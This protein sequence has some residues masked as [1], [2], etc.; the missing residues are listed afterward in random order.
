MRV[1]LLLLLSTAGAYAQGDGFFRLAYAN[2]YFGATDYYFTQGIRLDY[3]NERRGW[4]L[5]QEGYTPTS[6]RDDQIRY[7][8]RPYAG[9]LYAGF[10][11]RGAGSRGGSWKQELT[12]GVLGPLSLA[13]EEQR[14]IHAQTGNVEPRGWPYQVANDLLINYR[15]VLERTVIDRRFLRVG[16]RAEGRLGTYRS[17]LEAG[18]E[19][20]VGLLRFPELALHLRPGAR[21]VGYDATLQGGIFNR[22]SP[23]TLS[24]GEI[25]RLVGRMDAGIDLGGR[26][27]GVSFTRTFLTA[28]FAGGKAHDWGTVGL[29]IGARPAAGAYDSW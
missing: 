6:I 9:A 28:E 15:L 18:M 12:A 27:W 17:R 14:W 26:R 8:D 2:D 29:R 11:R 20:R 5:A 19:V 24:A 7:G 23:Y 13:A 21:L 25:R 3:G 10:W 22:S 1:L 4:L 16:G